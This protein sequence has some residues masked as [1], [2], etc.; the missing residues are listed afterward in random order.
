[1]HKVEYRQDGYR[2]CSCG[3]TTYG[4]FVVIVGSD[5]FCMCPDCIKTHSQTVGRALTRYER[6]AEE[7]AGPDYRAYAIPPRR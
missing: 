4:G 7:S 1:M 5:V 3:A 2:T 6:L